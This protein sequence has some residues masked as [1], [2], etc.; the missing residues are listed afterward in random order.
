MT[1]GKVFSILRPLQYNRNLFVK[2]TVAGF[3][4]FVM[5]IPQGMAY[6]MLAGLPP[7]YGL[8][9]ST[10]PVIIYA[11]FASSK[12]LSVGPVAIT[13]LL[14]V[15]GVSLYAEPGTSEYISLVLTLSVM[16]GVLQLL[17]GM[18]KA[19]AIVQF[20]SGAVMSGY[21]SAAAIVI[22]LSQL[23]HLLGIEI[24]SY[25]Q[26]HLLVFKAVQHITN[27]HFLTFIIGIC[28]IIILLLLK[29][30]Y[31]R[32]P[33]ALVVV[34]LSILIVYLFQLNQKGVSI[35]GEVPKGFPMI[36]LPSIDFSMLQSLLPMALTIALLGF[37][38]SLSIG[39]AIADQENYKVN[40]NREL[41]ALGLANTTGAFF[42][43]Y[44]INGSFS[45]TAVNYQTGGA[46]Q[47]SSIMTAIFVMITL[48]FFTSYFYYL[49]N[50]VLASIVMVA[51]YKLVNIKQ[52]ITY[53]KVKPDDGW[54][55][56][57]TFAITLIV[58]VK[59]GIILGVVFSLVLLLKRSMRPNV[60]EI[61]YVVAEQTFRDVLKYPNA[62]TFKNTVIIRIDSTLHFA[63]I[64]YVSEQ[65]QKLYIHNQQIEFFILD[66]SGVNDID[67]SAMDML[68][69]LIERFEEEYTI[70]IMLVNMKESVNDAIRK[71]GWKVPISYPS[72]TKVIDEKNL[73]IH[74]D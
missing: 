51:V 69:E 63:N 16:V 10:V 46:T 39:K 61:G 45:R 4:L 73:C 13:S 36:S 54:C 33:A 42:Q 2:D 70:S 49:P 71:Q 72:I 74:T 48:M 37:M 62:K 32:V 44:P 31:P 64:A 12:H 22:S 17:L 55:W 8:Y 28:S 47:M 30:Y 29:K 60:K 5:L 35:V 66:M 18:V 25:L 21:T 11:F 27:I 9:V 24:G 50:A 65:I 58:G 15:S 53:F 7:V 14:V 52:M 68:Q 23:K 3:T 57:V 6:A 34:M 1:T 26:T 43:G 40:P 56:V 38:E 41:I 20:I 67:T 59:W 19:G